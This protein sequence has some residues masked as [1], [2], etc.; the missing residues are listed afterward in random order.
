MA[1]T[2]HSNIKTSSSE[3]S[4]TFPRYWRVRARGDAFHESDEVLHLFFVVLG[5]LLTVASVLGPL[6]PF[7]IVG[8]VL[9]LASISRSPP[10][11]S[12]ELEVGSIV[13]DRVY[14][15][16]DIHWGLE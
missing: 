9:M 4:I 5:A 12:W 13:V 15:K 8:T 6:P 1:P 14:F 2:S 7:K 3:I 11:V 16:S 10:S